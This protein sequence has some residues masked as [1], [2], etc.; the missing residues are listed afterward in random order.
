MPGD[1]RVGRLIV[2][3]GRR[4]RLGL[5]ELVDLHH[6]GRDRAARRLPD[7]AAGK[8]AAQRQRAEEGEPPVLRLDAR[9]AD[10]LV[11][12]LAGPLVGR[13]GLGRLAVAHGGSSEHGLFPLGKVDL[14]AAARPVAGADGMVGGGHAA[15]DGLAALHA[16]RPSRGAVGAAV[17]RPEAPAAPAPPWRSL[18]ASRRVRRRRSSLAGWPPRGAAGSSPP[19]PPPGR[20]PPR[21]PR[22]RRRSRRRPRKRPRAPFRRSRH[23]PRRDRPPSRRC[24][25]RRC[26][27]PRDPCRRRRRRRA[28]GRRR[29]GRWRCRG[30]RS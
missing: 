4:D 11:P 25:R 3:H 10:A 12:D 9:R 15:V 13:L 7:E 30:R 27:R 5:A 21:R 18:R 6:P 17:G 22:D 14:A 24:R 2:G 19:I 26:R 8:A 16:L 1:L 20:R 29:S 28:A 23:P